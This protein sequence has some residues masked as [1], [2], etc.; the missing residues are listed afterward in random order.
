MPMVMLQPPSTLVFPALPRAA[1]SAA[2]PYT[3]GANLGSGLKPRHS[4]QHQ[5]E[6]N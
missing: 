2:D 6:G 5:G 1:L 4:A 3:S